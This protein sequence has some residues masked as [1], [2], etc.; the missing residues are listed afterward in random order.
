MHVRQPRPA[1]YVGDCS[2][3]RLFGTLGV[4]SFTD[5]G[6]NHAAEQVPTWPAAPLDPF[7]MSGGPLMSAA[8]YVPAIRQLSAVGRGCFGTCILSPGAQRGLP[9]SCDG[10]RRSRRKTPNSCANWCSLVSLEGRHSLLQKRQ[11]SER[12]FPLF[13]R[14]SRTQPRLTRFPVLEPRSPASTSKYANFVGAFALFRLPGVPTLTL[15][16]TAS[17]R[18]A[19]PTFAS[20]SQ[21]P[22]RQTRFAVLV[23]RSPASTSKDADIMRESALF[24]FAG[25]PPITAQKTAKIGAA[26]LTFASAS[27]SP[28]RQTRFAVLVRR[29][30]ASTSKD[31]DI[32]HELALLGFAEV[33]PLTPPKTAKI[34]AALH[35]FASAPAD[36]PAN[37]VSR[38]RATVA[39]EPVERRRYIVRA[40][41]PFRF[42]GVPAVTAP[43][44]AKI[45]FL[46][47]AL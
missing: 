43:K 5:G 21:T 34:R 24:R 35:T 45:F 16:K 47:V 2:L 37:A 25:V 28:P 38:T 32:V 9:Y 1:R 39:G 19:V 40:S 41:A 17:I 11:R 22:P 14:R 13:R 26:L 20:A 6:P 31:A 12:R 10:R 8:G 3:R 46:S 30:P 4:H 42:A 33:P 18:A 7:R 44:T 36:A 23:R 27:R 15:P 29:S